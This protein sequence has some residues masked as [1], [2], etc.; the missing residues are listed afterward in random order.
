M[1]VVEIRVLKRRVLTLSP[2][3]SDNEALSDDFV[4]LAGSCIR[5]KFTTYLEAKL[6][7][8][9]AVQGFAIGTTIR[10]VDPLVTESRR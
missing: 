9:Q 5:N 3:V 1:L 8:Q 6:S 10:V 2:P 7:L 4:R